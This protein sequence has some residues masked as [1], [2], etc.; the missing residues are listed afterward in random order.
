MNDKANLPGVGTFSIEHLPARLDFTNKSLYAPLPVIRFQSGFAEP[1]KNFYNYLTNDW[2]SDEV[3]AMR[4]FNDFVFD[5][6][7]RLS[8]DS[9][10]ILPHFGVLKKDAADNYIFEQDFTIKEFF[11]V[12]AADR[13][14][15]SGATHVVKTGDTEHT[16]TEMKELLSKQKTVK[17]N[18][19]VYAVILAVAG[20][21]AL[22]YY[23]LTN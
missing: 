1:D 12:V 16:N 10:T 22:V 15:R 4:Q 5:I 6:K 14:I 7:H 11:P 13:I 21:A 2:Q 3:A 17:D 23:N 20:L 18:W 9:E 19:W 8:Y